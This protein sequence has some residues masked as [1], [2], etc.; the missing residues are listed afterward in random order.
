MPL[1]GGERAGLLVVEP[2]GLEVARALD[3][4]AEL[5][6]D[7]LEEAQL[8]FVE[9]RAG[10]GGH[11]EDAPARPVEDERHAGVRHRLFE[12]RGDH[13][14]ARAIGGVAGLQPV[15]RGED[16][17]AEALAEAP[18]P[19]GLEVGERDSTVGARR[20][21]WPSRLQEHPRR[22]GKPEVAS[23]SSQ[24]GLD[25]LLPW[26]LGDLA[27]IATPARAVRPPAATAHLTL[28]RLL[29]SAAC[30]APPRA[31]WRKHALSGFLPMG[32][33][34][35]S[36]R[37]GSEARSAQWDATTPALRV[38]GSGVWERQEKAR[39]RERKLRRRRP[40]RPPR[41]RPLPRALP[42]TRRDS[43]GRR[44][45]P[46]PTASARPACPARSEAAR[47]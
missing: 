1:L 47:A 43:P 30:L 17:P 26:G 31:S 42:R 27:S 46:T 28:D 29:R 4:E 16:L 13:R 10:R 35:R 37:W 44:R 19:G 22:P 3:L 8:G 38:G 11:V 15:A 12:A 40:P 20:S 41:P 23:R 7:G 14:H 36:A 9:G 33:A 34:P 5:A 2:F 21:V 24:D 39:P 25:V 6:A 18:C 32:R 45:R